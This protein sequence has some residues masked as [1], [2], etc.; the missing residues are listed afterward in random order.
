MKKYH[1]ITGGETIISLGGTSHGLTDVEYQ[2][3]LEK[4]GSNTL[5]EEKKLSTLVLFFQQFKNPLIYILFVALIISFA[6]GHNVDGWIIVAVIALS[7]VVGFLQEHKA[8]EALTKLK[9]MVEHKVKVFRDDEEIVVTQD[10]IVPGDVISLA[11]GDSVPADARLIKLQNLEVIEA[12][13]TGESEPSEKLLEALPEDTPLAD[14]ENMVY[15]GT[16]IAR[17]NAQAVITATGSYTELGKVATMLRDTKD[18]KTPVQKQ[19]DRFGTIIAIVLVGLNM[20]IFG[21]GILSGKPMFEMF[22]TSVAVVVAAIPEGLLTAMAIILAVGMQRMA[23]HKGL[24]RKMVAAETLGSV[25]VICTDKTGTLT[26]GEMKVIDIITDFSKDFKFDGDN[27][28]LLKEGKIYTLAVK[29]GL[30]N[31]NAVVESRA[32]KIDDWVVVGNPTE[33]ALLLKGAEEDMT[34]SDLEKVEP[35]VNEIPFDSEY[36]FMAT[37]HTSGREELVCV[38]GAPEK[39]LQLSSH[40]FEGNDEVALSEEKKEQIHQ[41]YQSLSSS[42]LRVIAVAYRKRAIG[43][44]F[45]KDSLGDLVFVGLITLKDPLRPEAKEA[46]EEVHAAGIRSIIITG[47]HKLTA[48]AVAKDLGV[49]VKDENILEGAEMDTLSKDELREA[50]KNIRIFAR[51]EPRHKIQIVSALQDNGEV[52]AMTGDG[53]NDA[54]ALK[55]ADIGVALGSGTDV[56]KE[57]ADLVL[58][59]DNFKT[60]VIAVRGG[61]IVFNNIRRVMLYLL[62]FSFSEMIIISGSVLAGLPLSILPAQILWINLI[63][64]AAPAMGLAFGQIDEG[65][66]KEKPRKR[67]EPL[68]NKALKKRLGFYIVIMNSLLLGL[69]YYI[70]QTTQDIQHARTMVFASLAVTSIFYIYSVRGLNVSIL[71][72]N[73][74]S[75]K[76]LTLASVGGILMMFIALYVPFFNSVLET[77]RL[78]VTDWVLLIGYGILGVVVYE[79]GKK[80]FV[81]QNNTND[82]VVDI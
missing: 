72:L 44:E 47:D 79:I 43:G 5:P 14:R 60:I 61:R 36:K 15:M 27:S 73:P 9:N 64:D 75:N 34:K 63:Q 22:L 12:A 2:Q 4:Y 41:T 66:M 16:V 52:V 48:K 71:K 74:F 57:V 11:A 67:D 7:T 58:L 21:V 8:S 1:S 20:L 32:D 37:L 33:K 62:G 42:G 26:K 69:F 65:V 25:S 82:V 68:L 13:L 53:V 35:R 49:D 40:Y 55:K 6:T 19:L 31:N 10:K 81:V 46:L 70:L 29:I 80:L 23:K 59:D 50:V 56:T 54:P 3:R 30:L 17:G 76:Y 77:C 78:T 28:E 24:V 45:E 51:V 38:K 39:V 18:D